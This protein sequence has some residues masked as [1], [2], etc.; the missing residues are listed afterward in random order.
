[1][2]MCVA[3]LCQSLNLNL[4]QIL[5]RFEGHFIETRSPLVRYYCKA[6]LYER[7]FCQ[8][9]FESQIAEEFRS[10]DSA[11]HLSSIE[12]VIYVLEKIEIRIFFGERRLR[13]RNLLE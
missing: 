5:I 4:K 3:D 6:T 8:M 11:R 1:M 13:R 10:V 2:A 12:I 7:T 9:H